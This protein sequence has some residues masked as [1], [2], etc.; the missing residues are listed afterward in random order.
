MHTHNGLSDPR[1]LAEA[2]LTARTGAPLWTAW[3][4]FSYV[5]VVLGRDNVVGR[6]G[7][8]KGACE[9]SGSQHTSC[10]TQGSGGALH[11]SNLADSSMYPAR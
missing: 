2:C 3:D 6:R 8:K 11:V 4:H 7:G 5:V 10:T 1:S 9:P